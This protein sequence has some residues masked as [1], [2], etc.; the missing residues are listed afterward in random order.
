MKTVW[1]TLRRNAPTCMALVAAAHIVW[2][3][4]ASGG[5][6]HYLAA[7]ETAA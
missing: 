5:W 1:L 4:L 6:L 3:S 2:L 7:D